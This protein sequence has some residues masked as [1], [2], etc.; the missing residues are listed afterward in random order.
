[1][2]RDQKY[3]E[4]YFFSL[5]RSYASR[6]YKNRLTCIYTI[7]TFCK[8]DTG[9]IDRYHICGYYYIIKVCIYNRDP[10]DFLC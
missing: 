1:M 5:Q 2:S 8:I 10:I 9:M 3:R 7:Y 4:F 6:L